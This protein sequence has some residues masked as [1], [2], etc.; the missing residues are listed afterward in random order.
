MG[1]IE[2]E[3]RLVILE[4]GEEEGVTVEVKVAAKCRVRVAFTLVL[5]WDE[6]VGDEERTI[7]SEED[8]EDLGESVEVRLM[9]DERVTE[10]DPEE[11]LETRGEGVPVPL[12]DLSDDPE[13]DGDTVLDREPL[14]EEEEL[15]LPPV[16][17]AEPP[18]HLPLESVGE[19]VAEEEGES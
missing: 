10:G 2:S 18:P 13:G 1:V 19:W 8:E 16:A 7:E 17:L 6:V 15:P 12:W 14:A 3:P 9:R 4:A 5:L 11:D